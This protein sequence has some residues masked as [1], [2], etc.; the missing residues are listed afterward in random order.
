MGWP[1][2]APSPTM[3][4]PVRTGM[5]NVH[6]SGRANPIRTVFPSFSGEKMRKAAYL[7]E[8][9]PN[10]YRKKRSWKNG[11]RKGGADDVIN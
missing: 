3:K 5:K 11:C 8:I 1:F 4:D 10:T 2:L 6:E 7:W 9:P